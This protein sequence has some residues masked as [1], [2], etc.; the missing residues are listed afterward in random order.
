MGETH[1]AAHPA[2]LSVPGNTHSFVCVTKVHE[3]GLKAAVENPHCSLQKEN[4][5]LL[6]DLSC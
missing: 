4:L 6:N 3:F 5:G 2:C 1:A